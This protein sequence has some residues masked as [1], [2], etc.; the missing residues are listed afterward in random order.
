MKSEIRTIAMTVNGEQ[1]SVDVEV[2]ALLS[3][4]LRHDLRLTGTHVGCEHGV[5]GACTILVDGES[6]RSCLILAVQ[7]DGSTIETVESLGSVSSLS[8]LQEAF[9]ENHGLQCGFCTSGI[10]MSLCAAERHGEDLEETLGEVLGG[11]IC[12]CTGY[13]NIRAAIEAHWAKSVTQ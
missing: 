5:C 1:V 2:R 4:V 6:A 13:Q 12:R 11:H 9:R 10:L 8:A 3:D 7:A